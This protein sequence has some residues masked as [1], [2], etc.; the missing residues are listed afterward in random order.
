MDLQAVAKGILE[1]V[2]EW[3]PRL[4]AL[5]EEVITQRRNTQ[6]RS[7][8]MILGHMVDSASNNNHRMVH[9]QYRK[10][11]VSFP[12]YATKGN[13]DRW[14]AIQHYQEED[15]QNLVQIWKYSH[16]HLMHVI[17]HVDKNMLEQVWIGVLL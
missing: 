2:Q 6:N 17:S 13:N 16:L 12:N 11:P 4:R 15:W 10:S 5:H 8:R 1:G 3:E 9:L 7:V 14:I